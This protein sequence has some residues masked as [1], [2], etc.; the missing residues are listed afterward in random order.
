VAIWYSL[1]S[2]CK[3]FVVSVFCAEK[4]LATL[5]GNR[6]R[7]RRN[8]FGRRSDS[9]TVS[10]VDK[11]K[12]RKKKTFS[13]ERKKSL[14]PAWKARLPDGLVALPKYTKNLT[15]VIF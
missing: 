9:A 15:F 12:R 4:N 14:S 5:A 3:L 13:E 1:W 10:K 8:A 11:L 6:K 7:D 2:F